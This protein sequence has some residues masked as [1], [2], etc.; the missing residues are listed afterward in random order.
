METDSAASLPWCGK[1]GAAEGLLGACHR[2][3]PMP[4][5]QEGAY[6]GSTAEQDHE[7]NEC[8]EPV[9][10][11]DLE[12]RPA[13]GPPLLPTALGDVHIEAGAALHTG[14]GSNRGTTSWA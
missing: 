6:Q 13:E 2:P 14:W 4:T 9:V 10:L 8:L 3:L 12:A 11:D 1:E 5:P 7:D